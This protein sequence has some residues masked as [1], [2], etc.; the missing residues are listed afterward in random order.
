MPDIDDQFR[1]YVRGCNKPGCVDWL[2]RYFQEIDVNRQNPS[3]WTLLHESCREDDVEIARLLLRHPA[4][5]VN[6][7]NQVRLNPFAYAVRE[8]RLKCVELL[9]ADSRVDVG[10]VADLHLDSFDP[11][12]YQTC[13]LNTLPPIRFVPKKLPCG[14]PPLL[15]RRASSN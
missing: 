14:M 5:K 13:P 15:E 2:R 6:L 12:K 8:N 3:K 11:L 4:V 9:L 7:K 1:V 10:E